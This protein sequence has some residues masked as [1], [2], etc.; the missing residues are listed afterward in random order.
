[1][2]SKVGKAGASTKTK[3][4]RRKPNNTR[5]LKRR[6]VSSQDTIADDDADDECETKARHKAEQ[7][8]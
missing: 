6:L 4:W 2:P 8:C 1:M 3:Y 5:G 7:A